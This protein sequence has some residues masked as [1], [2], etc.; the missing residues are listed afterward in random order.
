M[1]CHELPGTAFWSCSRLVNS[2]WQVLRAVL[3]VLWASYQCQPLGMDQH[4]DYRSW[5]WVGWHHCE[6]QEL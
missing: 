5:R 6:G 3:L 2:K 4:Q 1:R